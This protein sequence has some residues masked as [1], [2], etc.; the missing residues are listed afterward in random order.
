VKSV[1][2]PASISACGL[3][4]ALSVML[5][6][7]LA[8]PMPDGVKV[9]VNWQL[10]PTGTDAGQLFFSEKS[11]LFAPI[12]A[13][14]LMVRVAL[15]VLVKVETCGLLVVLSGLPKLRLEGESPTLENLA[16]KASVPWPLSLV[17]NAPG[18]TG[19][20]GERVCP[21]T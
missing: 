6:L 13:I 15:A 1:P 8:L 17:W 3:L 18:V 11:L 5:M 19:K 4:S 21:V 20:S 14:E 16:T 7:A 12:T 9:T 10:L 2:T